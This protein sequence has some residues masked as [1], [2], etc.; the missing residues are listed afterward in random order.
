MCTKG[1]CMLSTH[2]SWWGSI[3]LWPHA[4]SL[5]LALPLQVCL[6]ALVAVRVQRSYDAQHLCAGQHMTSTEP[7]ELPETARLAPLASAKRACNCPCLSCMLLGMRQ[8]KVDCE[9]IS[10]CHNSTGDL[11]HADAS[12]DAVICRLQCVGTDL[13][14]LQLQTC[15]GVSMMNAVNK[16]RCLWDRP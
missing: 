14:H 12:M 8:W 3:A 13:G 9:D 7:T 10:Q 11:H 1:A 16:W 4:L 6:V 15:L 5:Q 2:P